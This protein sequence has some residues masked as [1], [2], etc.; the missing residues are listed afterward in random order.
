MLFNLDDKPLDKLPHQEDFDARRTRISDQD[1][2]AVESAL[3]RIV[4]DRLNVDQG[5]QSTWLWEPLGEALHTKIREA[6]GRDAD[7]FFGQIVWQVV[8]K[9]P[10][11]WYFCRPAQDDDRIAGTRYWPRRAET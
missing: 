6:A 7:F 8:R 2:D 4:A 10:D 5:F 1:Y 3:N 11:E 9:R